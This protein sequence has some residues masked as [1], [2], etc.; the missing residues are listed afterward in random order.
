MGFT[1]TK[2]NSILDG[3]FSTSTYIALSTTAPTDAGGN[4]TEPSTANGYKRMQATA[5]G[6][7]SNKQITNTDIIFFPESLNTGWGTITHFA[8][9]SAQTGGTPYYYGQLTTPVEVPA[10]YVPIFRAGA[11]TIGLDI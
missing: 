5:M 9:Y 11:L 7:A 4:V 6:K 8:L 3:L 2:A 1:T 10:G